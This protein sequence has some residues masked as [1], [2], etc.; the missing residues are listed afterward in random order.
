MYIDPI[1]AD[2]LISA[3]EQTSFLFRFN[4]PW[5]MS[6]LF[7][8]LDIGFIALRALISSAASWIPPK[9]FSLRLIYPSTKVNIRFPMT[10]SLVSSLISQEHAM[11]LPAYIG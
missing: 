7:K 9:H 11:S 2:S 3:W 6:L 8:K 5:E 4:F 1:C 10:T